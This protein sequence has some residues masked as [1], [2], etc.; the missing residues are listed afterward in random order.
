[1]RFT[2]LIAIAGLGVSLRVYTSASQGILWGEYPILVAAGAYLVLAPF[3]LFAPL[4][5]AH[6]AME[7][8]KKRFMMQVSNQLLREMD[9]AFAR[10]DGPPGAL[11]EHVLKIEYLQKVYEVTRRFPVWPFDI[12]TLRRFVAT[13]TA[14][15]L[16]IVFG[17]LAELVLDRL[18]SLLP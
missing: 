14:P 1:M 6:T 9:A 12:A 4:G 5:T 3:C 18:P 2:Y 7:E 10:L 11:K 8:V 13:I 15:V 16:P 17:F